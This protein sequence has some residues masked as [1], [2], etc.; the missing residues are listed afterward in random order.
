VI[1]GGG[2]AGL[3]VAQGLAENRIPSVILEKNGSLGG[4]AQE[5]PCLATDKCQRCFACMVDDLVE[6]AQESELIEIK[7]DNQ[8]EQINVQAGDLLITA[9][10]GSESS[11]V[12]ASNIVLATGFEPYNPA[13]KGFWGYGQLDGVLTLKDINHMLR[14]N[15]LSGLATNITEEPKVAF[16]QCVG[17]RDTSIGA[18]YC[19]QH[20]CKAALKSALKLLNLFPHWEITIFYIDLQVAGKFA[21]SLLD[22][23]RDKGIRLLQGVPGEINP[24]P[25]G[26]LEIIREDQGR[27]IKEYFDRIILSIGQRP[28]GDDLFNGRAYEMKSKDTGY[29]KTPNPVDPCRSSAP[30][31]YLAGACQGPKDMEMTL[32]SAGRTVAAIV[33]DTMP[34]KEADDEL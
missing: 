14:E 22:E 26:K 10:C 30:G 7:L 27:N 24:G 23:A 20:C 31:I 34:K 33:R 13:D 11:P 12:Q 4:W 8:C 5:W 6:Y 18:N 17:S 1:I 32:Q 2:P 21:S 25:T 16:F 3:A 15:D 19:S 28:R 9:Q 29:F